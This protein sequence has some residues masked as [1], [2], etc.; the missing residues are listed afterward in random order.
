METPYDIVMRDDDFVLYANDKPLATNSGNEV[1]HPNARLLRLAITHEIFSNGQTN[2]PLTLLMKLSDVKAGLAEKFDFNLAEMLESDPL[3]VKDQSKTPY[4]MDD[5]FQENP[6]LLDFIFLNSSSIAS[7]LS[8]LL[9]SKEENQIT[10]DFFVQEITAQSVEKQLIINELFLRNGSGI[11]IHYLLLN[12]SL[13]LTEYAAGIVIDRIK[14]R[15]QE[16]IQKQGEKGF[17]EIIR[18]IT[19]IASTA[20]DFLTLCQSEN[21]I[22]VIEEIIKRG[23]DNQTEFKSTLRW[24]LRQGI[25]NAAIEHASLKTICAFLNSEGGDLLIGVRDDGSIEGIETDKFENDDKFLLH[26]WTL[27][28]TC[29]GQEVVEWVKTTLQKF[30]DKTVCRVNC[31]KAGKPIFLNQK[32][33]DEAFFIRVGP[34]SSNLEIRAAL[35]YIKHH[36]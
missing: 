10:T 20:N 28:K 13:S 5:I 15:Q 14:N 31:R 16:I 24:D 30:G 4:L 26:L 29:M 3:L 22:S 33:F 25:K 18:Q 11:I 9:V 23:E 12:G 21:K 27:I 7:S 34:S 35:K 17:F 6:F 32:G 2:L 8:N 36:F 19:A 1:A